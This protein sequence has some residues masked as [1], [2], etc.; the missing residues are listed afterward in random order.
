MY[1]NDDVLN[2]IEKGVIGFAVGDAFGVP[3]EFTS[4]SDRKNNLIKDIMWSL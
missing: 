2:N 1:E 3:V 4:R